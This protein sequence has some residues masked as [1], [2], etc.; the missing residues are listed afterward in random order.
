MWRASPRQLA[1]L[2]ALQ[3]V[4]GAG[5]TA[6]LL[7]GAKVVRDVLRAERLDLG[8]GSVLPSLA[9]LIG[10]STTLSFLTATRGE[11]QRLL[12]EA[13]S[14]HAQ[15]RIIDAATTVDLEAYERPNFHDRLQRAQIAAQG[16]PLNL[17]TGITGMVGSV[18]GV[19]GLVAALL[20]LAP[21][22]VP[23]V[24][25]GYVP[26]WF[27]SV[28]NSQST[29]RF[30]WSMTPAD[31][32]RHSLAGILTSKHNAQELRVFGLGPFIRRR[33]EQL[34]DERMAK[35]RGVACTRLRRSLWASAAGSALRPPPTGC[36]SPSCCRTG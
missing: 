11:I 31:R 21:L 29:Y 14:R 35:L 9:L 20:A 19:V 15:E 24:V 18:V 10:V 7:I 27:A 25:F 28:R 8:I 3:V 30:G 33:Y 22:L 12:G 32:L 16:R 1:T 26:L 13:A 5:T 6:Q 36:S 23:I 2:A 34:Y 4:G 17:V